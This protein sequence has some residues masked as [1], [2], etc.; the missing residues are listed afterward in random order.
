MSF[1]VLVIPEDPTHNGY[2][3]KPLVKR[4]LAEAG[5]PNAEIVVLPNPR[6]E[7]YDQARKA[8]RGILQDKYRHFDL[9]LFCPDADL[10]K[11]APQFEAEIRGKGIIL[12]VCAAQ[13]EVEAWVLAG[14]RD[15][16]D[17]PF[18]EVRKHPRLKEDVFWP[19]LK[20]HADV[21]AAGQGRQALMYEALSN[22]RGILSVCPELRELESR[23][24]DHFGKG[25]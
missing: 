7:S 18:S 14:H 4:L 5:K 8:I 11:D 3:L 9:W 15:K 12:F 13:P 20:G 16:L 2:I 21:R 1:R 25:S 19:F 22:Y 24:K 6:V 17:L 23:L 10:C